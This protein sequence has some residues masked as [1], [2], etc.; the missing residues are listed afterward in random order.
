MN[1]LPLPLKDRIL[2]LCRHAPI[3]SAALSP[4]CF[5]LVPEISVT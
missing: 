2:K 4:P 1:E 3:G 5:S